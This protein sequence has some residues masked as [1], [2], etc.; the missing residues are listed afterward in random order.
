MRSPWVH[1]LSLHRGMHSGL[2]APLSACRVRSR[3]GRD[4][5]KQSR[6]VGRRGPARV[7]RASGLNSP[8]GLLGSGGPCWAT[9][10]H[11]PGGPVGSPSP[12]WEDRR[13]HPR[14]AFAGVQCVR[15]SV[16]Q[17]KSWARAARVL[18]RPARCEGCARDKACGAAG[19]RHG[20]CGCSCSGLEGGGTLQ[21][22]AMGLGV[23]WTQ[24]RQPEA[25]T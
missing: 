3:A 18:A 4:R 10:G 5:S 19:H 2:R 21:L 13:Q 8:C 6:A 7:V 16:H 11:S 1:S 23:G 15:A 24:P 14:A 12:L 22:A 20:T 25:G 9:S 17:R